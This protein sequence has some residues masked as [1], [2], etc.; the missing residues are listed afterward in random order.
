[1]LL[2]TACLAPAGLRRAVGRPG[3]G[4]ACDPEGRGQPPGHWIGCR[5]DPGPARPFTG[6]ELVLLGR[7]VDPNLGTAEDLASVPG[8]SAALAREIVA[9]R[10]ERGRFESVEALRRVRGI[11][12]VRLARARPWLSVQDP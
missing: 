2:L 3:P 7:P 12:P 8:L 5:G 11:G 6:T 9:D 10:Q 4:R 1:M